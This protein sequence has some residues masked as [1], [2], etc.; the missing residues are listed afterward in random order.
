VLAIRL[1]LLTVAVAA[2]AWFAL[3]V[4]ATHD[5]EVASSILSGSNS[6]TPQHA[7]AA[8]SEIA[9]AETLNPDQALEILRA[10]VELHSGNVAGAVAIAKAVVRRE[11]KN[12]AAWVVLELV[13]RR[14]DP[15]ANRLAEMRV[16]QLVPPVPAT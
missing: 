12:A 4:R 7:H 10:Q 1:A 8:L 14:I 13:S 5:T 16:N 3:G 2:C 15:A 6:L 9:A 11:P